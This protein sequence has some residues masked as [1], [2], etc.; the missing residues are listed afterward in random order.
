MSEL[1]T[2]LVGLGIIVG[3]GCLMLATII[4]PFVVI[5]CQGHLSRIAQTLKRIEAKLDTVQIEIDR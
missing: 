4:L 2:G 1:F 3:I 5:S